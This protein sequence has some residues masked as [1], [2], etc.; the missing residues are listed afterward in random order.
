MLTLVAFDGPLLVT[1]IVKVR[2]SPTMASSK[3][4]IFLTVRLTT[5]VTFTLAF[6]VLTVLFSLQV[7]LTIFVKVPF[8]IAFNVI[9]NI[10]DL[11]APK[12]SIINKPV[13]SL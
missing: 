3:S 7:T 10:Y 11:P 9:V 8:V 4:T 5:G 12:L 13:L 1:I 6:A 2:T